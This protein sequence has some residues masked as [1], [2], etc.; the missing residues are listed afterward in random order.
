MTVAGDSTVFNRHG[1]A[2]LKEVQHQA[3]VIW[4]AGGMLTN[5]GKALTARLDHA[6]IAAGISPGG[7]AD[8]LACTYFL[9]VLDNESQNLYKV[10]N[11][12]NPNML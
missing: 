9:Y 10:I 6:F 8:L 3:A 7:S 4:Q 2:G 5:N 1:L 12:N 11:N